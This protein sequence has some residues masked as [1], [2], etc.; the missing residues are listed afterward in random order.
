MRTGIGF[1]RSG[2][3][4]WVERNKYAPWGRGVQPLKRGQAPYV[5]RHGNG[6]LDDKPKRDPQ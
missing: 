3:P 1:T 6:K 4:V 2:Q 5:W